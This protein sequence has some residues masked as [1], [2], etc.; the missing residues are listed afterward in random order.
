MYS[1]Y[2]WPGL[3]GRGEFVRL[4]LEQAGVP[5]HDVGMAQGVEPILAMRDTVAGFAPP[6]LED[7]EDVLA[8]VPAICLYLGQKHGLV[9]A[10]QFAQAKAL[11]LFLSVMDVVGE[12]HD[13]HHP[14][15]VALTY[16]AQKEAA[17]L[18]AAVLVNGRLARWM[19][20]FVR[21]IESN[22]FLQENTLSI[23]DLALFQLVRGLEYAFPK[24]FKKHIPQVLLQHRNRVAELPR[25]SQYLNSDRRQG[26]NETGIFRCYPELDLSE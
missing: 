10:E 26:F 18:R 12:V 23:A 11:Q 9:P 7:G 19:R 3:P 20:Y 21:A 5:Y 8:Q 13:T 14:I 1:L 22:N 15:D 16:E 25:I 17:S 24:A 2:Y 4:V 6:Y